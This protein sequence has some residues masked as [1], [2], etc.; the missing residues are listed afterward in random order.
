MIKNTLG[1]SATANQIIEVIPSTINNPVA[2]D[3]TYSLQQ[4][5]SLVIKPLTRF[6]DDYDP[7]GL[8]L[9]IAFIGGEEVIGGIQE[10]DIT[11]ATIS[12]NQDNEITFIP[13]ANYSGTLAFP[14]VIKNTNGATG[15]GMVTMI[16]DAVVTNA[17]APQAVDD[18]YT[19]PQNTSQKIAPLTYGT[20]DIDPN[21]KQLTLTYINGEEVYGKLQ[22]IEV[23]NGKLQVNGQDDITFIPDTD[24]LGVAMFSYEISNASG[25]NDTGLQTIEVVASKTLGTDDFVLAVEDF[26]VYPNPSKG[27]LQIRLKSKIS[28]HARISLSDVTGKTVYSSKVALKQGENRLNYKFN[29]SPGILFL[30]VTANSQSIVKKVVF[31]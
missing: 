18:F 25:I 27:N 6:Y 1:E 3:D 9:S 11:N 29:V 26:V 22:T 16:V 4:G 20:E 19:I 24:Y 14:Y 30:R 28:T 2:I 10:I 7:N 12:I 17:A 5:T 8:E 21:G 23:P 31:K 15:T 13:D